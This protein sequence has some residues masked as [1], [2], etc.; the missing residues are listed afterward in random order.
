MSISRDVEPQ[1]RTPRKIYVVV[2]QPYAYLGELLAKA[3]EG[4]PGVEILVDQRRGERRTRQWPVPLE[5]RRNDRRNPGGALLEIVIGT[6]STS[7]PL[8]PAVESDRS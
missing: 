3:F 5:R 1:N 8:G 4:I 7:P 6:T 2:R